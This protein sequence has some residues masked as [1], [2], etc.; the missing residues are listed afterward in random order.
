MH[1]RVC[2]DDELDDAGP[3]E[4]HHQDP[5]TLACRQA[6]AGR[7]QQ[8][9]GRQAGSSRQAAAGRQALAGSQ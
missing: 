7:Q 8:Q 4:V 1:A 3:W 5:D 9:S 2:F 6:V